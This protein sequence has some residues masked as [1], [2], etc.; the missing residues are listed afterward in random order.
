MMETRRN[1]LS[2][3]ITKREAELILALQEGLPLHPR[4]FAVIGERLGM[5]E[6]AVLRNVGRF[7]QKGLARTLC[8]VFDSNRL[9]YRSALCAASVGPGEL[10]RLAPQLARHPGITHCYL[11]RSLPAGKG[12]TTGALPVIPNLWVTLT[13]RARRYPKELA[14][15]R[16]MLAPGE[17]AVLPSRRRFKIGMILDPRLRAGTDEPRVPDRSTG[18]VAAASQRPIR[19]T[20]LQQA[21]IRRLRENLPLTPEPFGQAAR[22]A[23]W[24]ADEALE[25]LRRWRKTGV[26]RRIA[27]VVRHRQLGFSANAMCVWSASNAG[28]LKAG[29][30]LAGCRQVTHCYERVPA[31]GFPYNL[32][33]VIHARGVRQ[34]TQAFKRLSDRA[35]LKNGLILIST[36]ELKRGSPSLFRNKRVCRRRA[37]RE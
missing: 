9:G 11:R 31:R 29:K 8:A 23:G 37:R 36:R 4:P 3:G 17:M 34:L 16:N 27:L 12:K 30:I 25:Q 5:T 35:G 21:L 7:F 14:K 1:M 19:V 24:P 26:L 32:Y 20:P 6:D 10:E 15:L 22:Q 28:T 33:A 13:V 18:T 2:T